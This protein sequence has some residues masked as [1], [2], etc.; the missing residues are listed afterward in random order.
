MGKPG[1]DKAGR[2]YEQF[3]DDIRS[4]TDIDEEFLV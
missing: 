2:P 1:H 4:K 3:A